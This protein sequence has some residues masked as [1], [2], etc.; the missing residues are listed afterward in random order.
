MVKLTKKKKA[1]PPQEPTQQSFEQIRD[2]LFQSKTS[3]AALRQI[4]EILNRQ[5]STY[6]LS[7]I[8]KRAGMPS[9][10]Y[11][12]DVMKGRRI[13]NKKYRAGLLRALHLSNEYARCI[14]LLI[15]IDSEIDA[16]ARKNLENDL[17][18]ARKTLKISRGN[19][20]PNHVGIFFAIEVFC[21]FGLF[22]NQPRRQ[23]LS[24][25]FKDVDDSKIG[26]ALALLEQMGLVA[27]GPNKRYQVLTNHFV[28]GGDQTNF[29]HVDF[30][31]LALENAITNVDRWFF[32][33]RRSYFVSSV[34]SVRKD[35]YEKRLAE[36]RERM[37]LEQAELESED[38]NMIV[39]FNMQIFP[40]GFTQDQET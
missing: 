28:L 22:Q 9:K 29:S 17:H 35:I 12:S 20:T 39:R 7:N 34:L 18:T 40:V 36:L 2:V 5:D 4:Y 1:P 37:L 13:L 11:L 10:G 30:F 23:D 8:C 33:K 32:D 6:S 26:S 27:L 16:K 14:N 25:Y 38:A 19:I 31:K 24:N 3:A 15:Q 21:A